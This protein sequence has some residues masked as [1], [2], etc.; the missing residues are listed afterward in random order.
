MKPRGNAEAVPLALTGSQVA[1]VM[2][3][4]ASEEQSATLLSGLVSPKE[5]TRLPLLENRKISRSLLLG[6]VVL[7]S[8]PPD[9][10]ERGVKELAQDLELPASTTYRYIHTLV[11]A[12]LLEQVRSSRRYRRTHRTGGSRRSAST[13]RPGTAKDGGGG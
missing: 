11:A 5:L 9:G 4:V 1:Q 3:V 2:E 13:R 12:G 7:I 6:L 10:G 8:F